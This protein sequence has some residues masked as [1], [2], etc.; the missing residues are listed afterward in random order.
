MIRVFVVMFVRSV[1]S[2]ST[3]G[4]SPPHS[5]HQDGS[6]WIMWRVLWPKSS[7]KVAVRFL[8]CNLIPL[9]LRIAKSF[10]LPMKVC[11]RGFWFLRVFWFMFLFLLF[12]LFVG[13]C[14][15]FLH[16]S[17]FHVLGLLGLLGAGCSHWYSG[18][19][20]WWEVVCFFWH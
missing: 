15:W 8:S 14:C 7:K 10:V 3:L 16:R 18:S 13:C 11:F 20:L 1:A 4:L 6:G 17:R 2:R 5:R 19:Q 12:L 9:K